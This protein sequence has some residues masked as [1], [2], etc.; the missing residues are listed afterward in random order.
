[1]LALDLY[2]PQHW[3]MVGCCEYGNESP[4]F[5]KVGESLD[6]TSDCQL[7]AII[8]PHDDSTF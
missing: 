7:V 4:N 3:A 5:V 8:L 2:R 6:R 1:M